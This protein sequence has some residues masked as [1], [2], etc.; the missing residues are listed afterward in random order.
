MHHRDNSLESLG[1]ML[2][3]EKHPSF[4][5]FQVI[6]NVQNLNFEKGL[7]NAQNANLKMEPDLKGISIGPNY[8][9]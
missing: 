1:Y 9:L 4:T 6:H 7:Y 2:Y 8:F 3:W 5:M